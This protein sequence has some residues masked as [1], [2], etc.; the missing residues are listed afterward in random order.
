ML[1]DTDMNGMT[2][3]R[4]GPSLGRL[5]SRHQPLQPACSICQCHECLHDGPTS[6]TKAR[7]FS[8]ASNLSVIR[9]LLEAMQKN[10]TAETRPISCVAA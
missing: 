2:L 8:H 1:C 10:S 5:E 3:N 4:A 9:V 6:V 7:E